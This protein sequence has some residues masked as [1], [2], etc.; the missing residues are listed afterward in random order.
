MNEA[1]P[2]NSNVTLPAGEIHFTFVRSSGPGGQNVNRRS[3]KAVLKWDLGRTHALDPEQK[4]RVALRLGKRVN[5]HGEVILS[6]DRFRS[7]EQ[8]VR[9]LRERLQTLVGRALMIPKKRKKVG[10]SRRSLE[11][12]EQ[13]KRAISKKKQLRRKSLRFDGSE[14]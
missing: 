9:D 7:R 10:V 4:A 3:T 11:A 8:N 2:I 12:K 6:S 5:H 1:L 13:T 14:R